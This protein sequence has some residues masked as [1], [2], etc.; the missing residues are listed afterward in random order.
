MTRRL[1][2]HWNSPFLLLTLLLLLLT[3]ATAASGF[4]FLFRNDSFQIPT[5]QN[6]NKGTVAE[7]KTIKN[8]KNR[9]ELCSIVAETS[10][11]SNSKNNSNDDRC[12]IDYPELVVFD[13]DACLWDQE[14]YGF[15]WHGQW[16]SCSFRL[17]FPSNC[18]PC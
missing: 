15:F 13:L 1:L 14:M 3:L 7:N 16:Y 17:L 2:L 9:L 18:I 10:K 5:I 4:L 6:R 12:G 11:D 8:R